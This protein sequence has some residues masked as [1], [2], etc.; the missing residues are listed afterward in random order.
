M[1]GVVTLVLDASA[2]VALIDGEVGGREVAEVLG[3]GGVAS[4]VNLAEARDRLVRTVRDPDAARKGFDLLVARGFRV[5]ACDL[6][7]AD[8]A[9]ELRVAHYHRTDLPVSLADCIGVAT[10]LQLG[11]TLVTS[12]AD[13]CRLAAIVG[14]AVHPIP[15]SSGVRPEA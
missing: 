5:V 8:R 13:Q 9:A 3:S 2:L 4:A 10:A 6:A 14:V 15:N 11:G 7:I 1:A 12:D